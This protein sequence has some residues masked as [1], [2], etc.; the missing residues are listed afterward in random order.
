MGIFPA[1]FLSKW[2][3]AFTAVN[4]KVQMADSASPQLLFRGGSDLTPR[5]GIDV[6]VDPNTGL[7][8]S[9]RG[10]SLYSDPS[11]VEKFGGAYRVAFIPPGLKAEQR[12]RHARHYELMPA[13]LMTFE[14]YVELLA[15]VILRAMAGQS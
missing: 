1:R 3:P 8:R 2:Q 5:L 14:R 11:P 15:Q 13:E 10:I 9:D 12:G 4:A 7:L 6:V